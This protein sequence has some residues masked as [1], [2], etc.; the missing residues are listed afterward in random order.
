MHN[1]G[2]KLKKFVKTTIILCF[3]VNISCKNIFK[4]V[5]WWNLLVAEIIL[6][7]FDSYT[8]KKTERAISFY[9]K[10]WKLTALPNF[11]SSLLTKTTF[12]QLKMPNFYPNSIVLSVYTFWSRNSWIV[13]LSFACEYKIHLN[14]ISIYYAILIV[15]VIISVPFH[16]GIFQFD[17]WWCL[18]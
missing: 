17:V 2:S 4:F 16:H 9:F 5:F 8:Q 3:Q 10:K 11:G 15:A 1:I 7:I 18:M 14:W 12:F 6:I 13:Q